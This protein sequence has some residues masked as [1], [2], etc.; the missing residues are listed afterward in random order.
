M[1]Q[2][3]LLFGHA[4]ALFEIAAGTKYFLAGTGQH[5]AADVAGVS[6]QPI[7]KIE[8]VMTRL[9]VDCVANLRSIE[10]HFKYVDTNHFCCDGLV[11][12]KARHVF[13]LLLSNAVCSPSLGGGALG[14]GR[15][16]SKLIGRPMKRMPDPGTS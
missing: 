5:D 2:C 6:G 8:Q 3:P 1:L 13:F 11:G 12:G 14:W 4:I 10:C 9:C 7:P 16:P 15:T